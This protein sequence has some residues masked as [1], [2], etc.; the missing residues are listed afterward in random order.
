MSVQ[1]LSLLAIFPLPNSTPKMHTRGIL[2]NNLKLYVKAEV[3]HFSLGS[4]AGYGG[5][6][7]EAREA[8]KEDCRAGKFPPAFPLPIWSLLEIT[9]SSHHFILNNW[10]LLNPRE[11]FLFI[12]G[13]GEQGTLN[14]LLLESVEQESRSRAGSR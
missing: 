12:A 8:A 3:F 13:N 9:I 11:H 7:G 6:Q 1:L 2:K 5:W 4:T 10:Q 14:S